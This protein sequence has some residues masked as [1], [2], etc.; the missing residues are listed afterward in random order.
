MKSKNLAG[1]SKKNLKEFINEN[2]FFF[3]VQC[4]RIEKDAFEYSENA[5][6]TSAKLPEGDNIVLFRGTATQKFKKGEVSRNNYKID[7][8]G[9]DWANYKKNPIILLQHEREEPIG[10]TLE[11]IPH[12][13]GIDIVYYVDLL[14]LD[15]KNAHRMNTG[16]ISMLST[17][18]LT[19][20]IKFEDNKTGEL[21]SEED[22]WNLPYSERGNYDLMISK[23]EGIEISA[24]TIGS[25]PDALTAKNS[26]E[27]FFNNLCEK[28]LGKNDVEEEEE[29]EEAEEVKEEKEVEEV[30]EET[31]ETEEVEEKEEEETEKQTEPEPTQQEG[32]KE[33]GETPDAVS[34]AAENAVETN[35]PDLVQISKEEVKQA[36]NAIEMLV[37]KCTAQQDEIAS[38]KATLNSIP[39]PKGLVTTVNNGSVGKQEPKKQGSWLP[40]LFEAN[41]IL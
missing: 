15:E 13:N 26:L 38:L 32:E 29:S 16:L 33:S 18:H 31:E 4:E 2:G 6:K 35:S 9:W 3:H 12:E 23:A 10:R 22:F 40:A 41:G 36:K 27:I 17:G 20:E 28:K 1:L 24:V 21:I 11:I 37:A 7:P 14:T 5:I 30:K 34:E 8:A 39:Q 25:N 19:K